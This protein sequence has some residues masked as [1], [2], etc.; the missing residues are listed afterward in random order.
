MDTSVV[1]VAVFAPSCHKGA[2]G[3]HVARGAHTQAAETG[4]TPHPH[5]PRR[6]LP[7]LHPRP[8][9]WPVRGDLQHPGAGEDELADELWMLDDQGLGLGLGNQ[10]HPLPAG[11]FRESAV[12]DDWAA[13]IAAELKASGAPQLGRSP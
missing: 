10:T 13:Q 12:I 8:R 9:Y 1:L 6:R 7:P 2:V 4:R 3:R 11:D 5:N